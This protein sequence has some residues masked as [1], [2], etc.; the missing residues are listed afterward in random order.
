MSYR[1]MY[2]Q[3]IKDNYRVYRYLKVFFHPDIT[4]SDFQY[5][6]DCQQKEVKYVIFSQFFILSSIAYGYFRTSLGQTM[7][8]NLGVGIGICML[9]FFSI[10]GVKMIHPI[11]MDRKLYKAGLIKKYEIA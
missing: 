4:K 1:E 7:K 8:K 10:V 3:K 2:N 6:K 11:I 9:P 5:I